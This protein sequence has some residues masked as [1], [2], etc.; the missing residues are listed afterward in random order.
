MTTDTQTSH[1]SIERLERF[2]DAWNAHDIDT[3][4]S[5]FT[6]SG[7]YLASIGPDDGGTAFR[8]VD[9]V[10]R[11]AAAFLDAYRDAHYTDLVI[12]L[13]GDRAFA[14]WTFSGTTAAGER[15]TYRGV[16]L[17]EF[18]G[19]LIALKNAYRKERSDPIG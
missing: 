5:F 3:I 2:F 16:D 15:I 14:S 12:G 8:G 4:A 17:F 7:V 10:R 18:E 13:A 9:E 19:D 11:G 6:P 1:M